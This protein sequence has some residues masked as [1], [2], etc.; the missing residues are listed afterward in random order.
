LPERHRIILL[1]GL[2]GSGKSTWAAD[3]GF[4]ALSSDEI[5][6]TLADD[7]TDQTIHSRV[8]ATIRY[9]LR[10]RIGIG[11]LATCIDATHLTRRERRPYFDIARWYD[12]D[13]E[14]VFFDVPLETCLARNRARPRQV[15]EEAV[16]AMAAKLEPPDPEEGFSRIERV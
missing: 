9:L 15:P 14:A 8:F 7:P 4:H 5:R 3:H 11:R 6:L 2:P 12:C 1:I 13:V 16:I 10:Q